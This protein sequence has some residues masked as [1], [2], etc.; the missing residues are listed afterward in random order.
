MIWGFAAI[1][2]D[3][4][5]DSD[6]YYRYYN[7]S[8]FWTNREA[9]EVALNFSITDIK[10]YFSSIKDQLPTG[11]KS[12]GI[13][14]WSPVFDIRAIVNGTSW[15]S[16]TGIF[17]YAGKSLDGSFSLAQIKDKVWKDFLK[18]SMESCIDCVAKS[19]DPEKLGQTFREK[20][21]VLN[22]HARY[23]CVPLIMAPP[24]RLAPFRT[25][26][27]K[28][29]NSEEATAPARNYGGMSLRPISKPAVEDGRNQRLEMGSLAERRNRRKSMIRG[30][31]PKVT[32]PI[33]KMLYSP[34]RNPVHKQPPRKLKLRTTN[35][36]TK[37]ASCSI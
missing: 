27:S 19:G 5:T 37:S 31:Q 32:K 8:I 29:L 15:G 14:V 3:S 9:R 1:G 34:S 6:N 18:S 23:S 25:P 16:Y 35:S 26:S 21:L 11:K 28:P 33:R 24:M 20:A 12:F 36:R 17:K 22:K 30:K 13:G 2:N 4:L 10:R 7:K